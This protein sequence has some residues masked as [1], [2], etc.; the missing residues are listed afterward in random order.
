MKILVGSE[1]PVKIEA[2][3]EAF[4]RYFQEFE[5]TSMAVNSGVSEQPIGDD[6]FKGA[7]K[8]AEELKRIN[9]EEKIGADVFVGIEG[10]IKKLYS[11]WFSFGVVCI[12]DKNGRQGFGTSPLFEIPD[13]V[14]DSLLGGA[15]LGHV[16]DKLTGHD[17]T[18]QHDGA[19]GFFT[20]GRMN[21][22]ELY[23]HGLVVA[24]IPLLNQEMFFGKGYF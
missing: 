17:N 22:K 6:T 21:R 20:K 11:R 14:K 9:E 10:G 23:S 16:M 8:R 2:V 19:I 4:S 18:K 3:R 24:M 13:D 7:E 1:N 5:L 12:M 15:E